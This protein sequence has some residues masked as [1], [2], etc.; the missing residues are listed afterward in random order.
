MPRA[1]PGTR[2]DHVNLTFGLVNIPVSVYPGTVSDHGIKKKQFVTVPVM[3]TVTENGQEVTRQIIDKV[4]VLDDK[5]QPVLDAQGQ[6][7]YEDVPRFEDHSVGNKAYDKFTDDEVDRSSIIKKIETAYGF[8]FVEDDEIENLFEITPKSLRVIGFQPLALFRQGA[9]VPRS[10]HYIEPGKIEQGKKKIVS[11]AAVKS[12]TML[13]EAMR[14]EG[15]MAVVELTTRGIPKPAVLLS[16]GT[17]WQ[18]YHTEE[19]R[20][21]RELPEIEVAEAEVAMAQQFIKAMWTEDP[22]DLED[23]RT[24]LIQGFADEK[25]AAGDFGRSET[26]EDVEAAPGTEDSDLMKALEASLALLQANKTADKA[27]G[28]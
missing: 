2:A 7:T 8:V 12:L 21:Q 17:L 16:D 22:M 15:A 6:A 13:L 11:K 25:A 5:D 10:L 18:V 19:I 26:V 24:A 28:E 1:N 4:P 14:S 23:K 3:E 27:V 20:Q 9:Y